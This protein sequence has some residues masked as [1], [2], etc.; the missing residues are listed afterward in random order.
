MKD[1]D[2]GQFNLGYIH[3]DLS[4][5]IQ[6]SGANDLTGVLYHVA[7]LLKAVGYQIDG[8]LIVDKYEAPLPRDKGSLEED[9]EELAKGFDNVSDE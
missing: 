5:N 2:F 4:I 1:F 8:D 9:L 6:F 3:D 7:G